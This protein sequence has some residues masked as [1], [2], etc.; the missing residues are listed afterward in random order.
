VSSRG[1]NTRGITR[2]NEFPEQPHMTINHSL[3]KA[4][5]D[6]SAN[7]AATEDQHLRLVSEWWHGD[8]RDVHDV[9][10]SDPRAMLRKIYNDIDAKK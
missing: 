4:H 10:G 6:A 1:E 9:V 8:W 2:Q 7:R 3:S 5:Q